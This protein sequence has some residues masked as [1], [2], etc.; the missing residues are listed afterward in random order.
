M[1]ELLTETTLDLA[2][3]GARHGLGLFETIRIEGGRPLRLELHHERLARGAAFLGL[4]EPPDLDSLRDFVAAE[5]PCGA[6]DLGVLRLVAVDGKLLAWAEEMTEEPLVPVEVGLA[7]DFRRYSQSPLN[8]HKTLSYLENSKLAREAAALGL[9]DLLALNEQGRL[10][11]GS[12]TSLL[13]VSGK[14]VLTPPVADGALPGTLRELLLRSGLV[15]EERLSPRE[16][17]EADAVI[18]CNALRE[19]VP[20][21]EV[22]GIGPKDPDP[23]A[24]ARL[25]QAV[26][27]LKA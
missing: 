17:Q 25:R 6:L 9:F 18:L 2:R 11:D 16:L 14:E 22:R 27:D 15:R 7:G 4:D 8:R 24:L 3:S 5:T 12:R 1:L 19:C 13:L 23:P 26:Q 20:V 21:R 10:T